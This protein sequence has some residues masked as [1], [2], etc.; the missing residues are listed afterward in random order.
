MSSRV[1]LCNER[2]EWRKV[3]GEIIALDLRE[4]EYLAVNRAGVLLW[5]TLVVG[6]TKEQ[7]AGVLETA[8]GLEADR[9]AADVDA[10]LAVLTEKG[11]LRPV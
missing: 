6:S 11:L 10:F 8:Y 7:L 9:A 3:E 5:E 4:N 1:Q 2:M